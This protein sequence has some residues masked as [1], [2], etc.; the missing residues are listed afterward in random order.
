MHLAPN[1]LLQG[2]YRIRALLAQGGMGAVYQATDERLGNTVALKQTLMSDPRL[3]AAFER[4]ARLLAGLHHPA[5]PV[6][7]DH[8]TEDG[9]QFL[10]MQYI[11]GDDLASML[12]QRGGPFPPAEALPWAEQLLDALD[13]LHTRAPPI[14]H[15]DVKPQNL[16]LNA[17][18][19][20]FLLDFGLAKGDPAGATAA[21]PSL[22]GYTPQYASLEQI[23]GSGTNARSDLYSVGASL[24]ELL[25]GTAPPDALARAAASIRGEPDPL[26]PA[27]ELNPQL[28]AALS[29]LLGQA[30]TLNPAMRPA[31]AASMRAALR[32][33]SASADAGPAPTAATNSA[34]RPTI[35]IDTPRLDATAPQPKLAAPS[36]RPRLPS[37]LPF[38][39][40]TAALLLLVV[41]V[42]SALSVLPRGQGFTPEPSPQA[43]AT[44]IGSS[45]SHTTIEG[46]LPDPGPPAGTTRAEPL[47]PGT[48]LAP[49]G[50]RLELLE[51]VRGADANARMR[52]ANSNNQPPPEGAEYLLLRLRATSTAA[53]EQYALSEI[54]LVGERHVVY[55]SAGVAPSP[56]LSSSDAVAP[57]ASIEGWV[58]YLVGAEEQNLLLVA[59]SLI[60]G[61]ARIMALT[62]GAAVRP[63]SALADL[64]PNN[65]GADP[66][67]PADLDELV[68]TDDWEVRVSQLLRGEAA[69]ER[70]YEGNRYNSEPEEGME[71]VLAYVHLRNIADD[72]ASALAYHSLFTASSGGGEI[73]QPSIVEPEPELFAELFPG[74]SGEGWVAVQVPIGDSDARLTFRNNSLFFTPDDLNTRYFALP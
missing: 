38:A 36:Q 39:G 51:Y 33:A 71:Y 2:R 18:G 37:C 11:P 3:R 53:Q 10:V 73:K 32:A 19:D 25:T 1:T 69:W 47:L 9:G 21:S 54:H 44:Q 8:F 30:L 50:W 29:A 28:P 16:K 59:G 14:V 24:Y 34:G 27:H 40:A 15:R 6:V 52:E 62:P 5:L 41:L 63:D 31:S 60:T 46:S 26:R 65:A 23:Q 57:G 42:V 35:A 7:S 68:I 55:R 45:S 12:R 70:I 20:L 49:V 43:G 58:P 13:F 22:Y 72:D 66:R 61:E 64:A 74:G 48:A 56:T 4:E 67:E 17:R